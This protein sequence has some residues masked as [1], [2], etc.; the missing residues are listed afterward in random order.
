MADLKS[1]DDDHEWGSFSRIAV[2]RGDPIER[3][4][5]YAS[6]QWCVSSDDEECAEGICRVCCA[7]VWD[8]A[9]NW[10]CGQAPREQINY[11]QGSNA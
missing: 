4:R 2:F 11:R 10:P 5:N 6:H 8:N 3:E 1:F 9:A 7:S